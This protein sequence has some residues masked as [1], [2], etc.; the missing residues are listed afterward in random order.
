M[1]IDNNKILTNC[2][3][4][5]KLNNQL[6]SIYITVTWTHFLMNENKKLRVQMFYWLE[7][8]WSGVQVVIVQSYN[9]WR[10]HKENRWMGCLDSLSNSVEWV[11]ISSHAS[12]KCQ[13]F[14]LFISPV[15]DAPETEGLQPNTNQPPTLYLHPRHSFAFCLPNHNEPSWVFSSF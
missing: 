5:E 9:S 15:L 7:W 3:T 6:K 1:N 10:S 14:T 2:F 11:R 4:P 12:S 13:H 8:V